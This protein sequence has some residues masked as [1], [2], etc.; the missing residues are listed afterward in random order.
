MYNTT[1]S[2]QFTA[3]CLYWIEISRYLA[4]D[5]GIQSERSGSVQE[6]V[7][8]LSGS[9]AWLAPPGLVRVTGTGVSAAAGGAGLTGGG[10]GVR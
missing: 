7:Q 9:V 1:S 3:V 4:S 5:I 6:A 2:S 8:Y 10:A